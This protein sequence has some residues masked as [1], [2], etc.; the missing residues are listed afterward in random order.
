L[1][2]TYVAAGT[3]RARHIA[4]DT[5]VMAAN[6]SAMFDPLEVPDA[7]SFRADRPWETYILWGYG[8]HRCFGAHINR[9]VI[10]AILKPLLARSSLRPTSAGIDTG[11][12][13]F[14][15]HFEVEFSDT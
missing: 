7:A 3:L 15:V 1:R 8:M 4:K 2:D 13:P 11:G 5:L 6:L 12:T 14:P 9:A 10:P